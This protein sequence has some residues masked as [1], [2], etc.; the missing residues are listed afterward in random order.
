M[1]RLYSS[2]GGRDEFGIK[3]KRP[4]FTVKQLTSKA[5]FISDSRDREQVMDCRKTERSSEVGR[6]MSNFNKDSRPEKRSTIRFERE[7]DKSR[8]QYDLRDSSQREQSNRQCK[9]DRDRR[10]DRTLIRDI[11]HELTPER[12]D[13]VMETSFSEEN[14]QGGDNSSSLPNETNLSQIGITYTP[15]LFDSSSNSQSNWASSVE[16]RNIESS[17]SAPKIKENRMLGFQPQD[18]GTWN[19]L[20]LQADTWQQ[21]FGTEMTSGHLEARGQVMAL[22]SVPQSAGM[23]LTNTSLA[24]GHTVPRFDAYN[25]MQTQFRRY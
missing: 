3:A 11:R 6:A 7:R 5:T 24:G 18:C 16:R 2:C 23:V 17:W 9:R 8:T 22:V 13:D 21:G 10:R 25:S 20:G 4:I 19:N 15:G 14:W 1:K 12:E